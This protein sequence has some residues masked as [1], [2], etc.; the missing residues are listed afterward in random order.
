MIFWK[1]AW[2]VNFIA[3]SFLLLVFLRFLVSNFYLRIIGNSETFSDFKKSILKFMRPSSN[4]IFNSHSPNGITLITTLRLGLSHL[5]EHKFRYN[6]LD[7]LNPVCS[8][9]DDIENTIHY[10]LHCPNYLDERRIFKGNLLE[11]TF[12]VKMISK[13]QNCSYLAFLQIRMH[14]IHVF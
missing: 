9:G 8:C 3:C 6:I 5:R 4:F 7:T 1:H 2:R 14:Q 11:K 13:S 12:M 10:L